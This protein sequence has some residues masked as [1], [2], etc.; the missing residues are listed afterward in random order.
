M[1]RLSRPRI[2]PTARRVVKQSTSVPGNAVETELRAK[3]L[4][5]HSLAAIPGSHLEYQAGV[6]LS[7]ASL[8]T[9]AN[10]GPCKS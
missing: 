7:K 5:R 9:T 10:W 1:L 3:A 2:D 8:T 6:L 4:S